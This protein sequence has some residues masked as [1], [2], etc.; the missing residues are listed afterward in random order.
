[1][2]ASLRNVTPDL[3]KPFVPGLAAQGVLTADA[4]L[5]GSPAAPTGTIRV[6]ARDLRATSGPAASVPPAQIL[7]NITLHGAAATIDA[8][9]SAGPKLRL[10][11][12]GTAPLKPDGALNMRATGNLDLTLLDPILQAGGRR[13]R[14][15]MALDM[16]AT[17]SPAKPAV[18]GTATLDGGEIQDFA[19]G[20]RISD[21]SAR[22]E[23]DGD[24]VRITRFAG[25][26]GPG[27][28]DV[29]GTVGVTAP[30]MPVDIHI[31][32]HN[33]RPLSSDLLT[34]TL[35]A[36]LSVNGQAAGTMDA[37]G[38]ILL[39]KVEIN[40]PDALPPSIALLNV[41]RPGDKPAPPPP[42]SVSAIKLDIAVDAPSNIFV[43][44][45]G[46]DTELGGTLHIGG[47][48]TAPVI[49]GGFD[50]RRGDFSL[51]GTTLNF[52]KGTVGFNG[53]GVQ[54]KIDPTLN[55]EADSYQGG[56]TATL[57]ITGYADAPKIAL[58]SV[59][60]LPQDE[61]LA[62]LLFGESMKQLSAIQ[63]AE[64]G[65]ALAEISGVAGGGNPLD[66]VRKGLG[67]DRL[68]V[69]GGTNG[70]GASVEAGRY[71]A[72]G[73]YVGA[74]QATSGAGGT[75]A[76][77]QIDL[78]R[79]LKLQTTLGTGGGSTQGATPENDPGSSLGLSYQFEY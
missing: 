29:T 13:V 28:L 70:A 54:H 65:A 64:I 15:A 10:A 78:T 50:M 27:T 45:H 68:S 42:A 1:V 39:H 73:V 6:S 22:V 38:K 72:K 23:A 14:G 53:T 35:D 8:R 33:A 47:L 58:S 9:V 69:G 17:G 11:A 2:T 4:H 25:H 67:L 44:G 18:N 46:L 24:T 71:V 57:K 60:D 26:A 12:N 49:S 16:A 5:T 36:D 79:H 7:A 43:R 66:S 30:G 41:R 52:T 21:I 75:Q 62:H 40:V 34:A 76:E 20:A 32:A 74:K 59:P 56:I 48:A 19:Q 37:A 51:A 55:F 77:V 3:A 31:T 63:I 61:V